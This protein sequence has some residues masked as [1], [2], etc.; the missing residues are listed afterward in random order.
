MSDRLLGCATP[1]IALLNNVNPSRVQ[2]MRRRHQH[3]AT[4]EIYVKAVRKLLEGGEEA[5]TQI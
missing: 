2:T 4:T 5:V 3:Y 1:P